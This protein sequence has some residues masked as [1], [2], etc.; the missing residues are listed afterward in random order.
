MNEWLEETAN[1]QACRPPTLLRPK[2]LVVQHY[3]LLVFD[4]PQQ[5]SKIEAL[6]QY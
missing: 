2:Q 3:K 4:Q 5:Q 1:L 6:K